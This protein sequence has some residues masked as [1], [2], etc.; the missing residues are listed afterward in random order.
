MASGP[1]KVLI[2]AGRLTW[3]G[4]GWPLTPLLDRLERRGCHVQVLCLSKGCDLVNDPR[5]LELPKLGNRWLRTFAIRGLWSHDSLERPD[6]LHVVHDEMGDVAL[7]LS[8]NA[9][10]PY[11]QTVSRFG[12]V[13]R[14]LRLSRRWCRRLVAT[15]PDLAQELIDQL[16]FPRDRLAVIPPGIAPLRHQFRKA[17]DGNVPV[18][19]TGGPLEEA[20]GMMVFLEAARLVLDAGHDVEFLIAT[21]G[22]QQIVLRHYAQRLRIADRVTVAN[23]PSVG[24][25]FWSVLDIYCQ[26]AVVASAGRTLIQALGHAIPCIATDVQGLRAL[27]DRGENGMIVAPGDADALKDALIA[28][29]DHPDEARR[30]GAQ[31]SDRARVNFDPEVEADRLID[32]YR[33]AVG[34]SGQS[35][36]PRG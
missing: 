14:G 32:V 19:G 28:I 34:I 13:A 8:E 7:D 3:D 27:I 22:T 24:A 20:S 12:T 1:L 15:S 31:A 35:N 2:L 25:D 23:Y 36:A 18:I 29:L 11:V 33:Q 30:L 21:Q 17:R 4:G 5:A 26:P 10:L 16:G 6:L 9:G